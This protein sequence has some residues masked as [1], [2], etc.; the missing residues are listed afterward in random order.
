[1]VCRRELADAPVRSSQRPHVTASMPAF[2]AGNR[3]KGIQVQRTSSATSV[4]ASQAGTRHRIAAVLLVAV[5]LVVL[6][7][8]IA[9]VMLANGKTYDLSRPYAVMSGLLPSMLGVL[10]VLATCARR[11]WICVILLLPFL[12]LVPVETA[13]IVHYGEPTWYAII[14]TIVESNSRRD[15]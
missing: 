14:A 2:A 7:P 5:V 10:L 1:M 6:L 12:P 11:P 3:R 15:R 8:N 13:Y 9:W 4:P